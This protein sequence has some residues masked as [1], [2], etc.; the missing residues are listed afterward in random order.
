MADEL[1]FRHH[2]TGETLYAVIVNSDSASSDHGKYW[3]TSS[4][5]F[6]TLVTANWGDYDTA[7][8][9]SPSGSHRFVGTFPSG[10]P[11]GIYDI[12]VFVRGGA[13]PNIGDFLLAEAAI[14]WTGSKIQPVAK[15]V[16]AIL[17]VVAGNSTFAE[18][19]GQA[20]YR[21]QD[22]STAAVSYTVSDVG[23]RTGSTIS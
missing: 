20:V 10:I 17:A 23:T 1:Q 18:A 19:T 15:A 3:N 21:K 7:L 5:A 11:A 8:T 6:E 2:Q 9:E 13:A 22:G 16:E 14:L 4:S 12:L